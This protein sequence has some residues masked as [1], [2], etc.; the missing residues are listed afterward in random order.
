MGP[1]GS[2]FSTGNDIS[3]W[4]IFHLSGGKTEGNE[5]LISGELLK[6][7]YHNEMVNPFPNS[8]SFQPMF[9]IT[10]AL[11]AYDL[12]WATS[13]YRGDY[14]CFYLTYHTISYKTTCIIFIKI[15]TKSF[16]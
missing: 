4:M 13:V 16:T 8:E 10:D 14:G 2:I 1:A 15:R 12:G 7:T 9:P 11:V 6:Q 5:T 3:K